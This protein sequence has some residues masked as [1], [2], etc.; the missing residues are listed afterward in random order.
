[1]DLEIDNV[2]SVLQRC[3]I[4]ADTPRGIDIAAS[5]GWYWITRATTEGVRWLD[6]LLAPV[7]DR[8]EPYALA[9]FI[10]GF[11]GV[12]QADPSAA[13]PALERAAAGA[14]KAGQVRLLSEALAMA[15]IAE[16]MAGD[17]AAA[18]LRLNEAELATAGLDD[19]LAK[20]ATLQARALNGFFE[21]NLDAVRSA[22]SEGARLSRE[23]GDLYALEMHLMN[24]GFAALAAGDLVESKPL[25]A[26]A[27]R[28]GHQID[29]RVAQFYSLD[30]L[31]CHA[32][33]S[34]HVR[35][36]ARLLGA[37]EAM[38]IGA[39]ANVNAVSASLRAQ[40]YERAAGAL[41]SLKFEAEFNAGKGLTRDAAVVLALGQAVHVAPAASDDGGAGLLGKREAD[42]ARLVADGL[43]NKQIGARLLISERTVESHVR[44]I[45]N[46]LGFNSRAQVAAWTATSNQ[47][48]SPGS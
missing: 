21:G 18:N 12:L 7:R 23:A 15:S 32:A 36:A 38:R 4:R 13:R 43:S 8:P 41:G 11:L 9:H 25:F 28:I 39:G 19:Y 1:M 2:R 48:R 5:M 45:L 34:G 33:S 24:L 6:E 40:G 16:N 26:D 20:V 44:S 47:L 3:V 30:A 46:K 17:R 10:R 31:G 35:L 37:A 22:S 42:V 14:R 29:D 27:L